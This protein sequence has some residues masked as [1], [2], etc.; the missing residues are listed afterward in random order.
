MEWSFLV[1]VQFRNNIHVKMKHVQHFVCVFQC[2]RNKTLHFFLTEKNFQVA[3]DWYNLA[4]EIVFTQAHR[5]YYKLLYSTTDR[6]ALCVEKAFTIQFP[7]RS[8]CFKWRSE[9]KNIVELLSISLAFFLCVQ[10]HWKHFILQKFILNRVFQNHIIS[11]LL[12][13]ICQSPCARPAVSYK[14]S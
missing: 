13:Q 1:E 10:K 6:S 5:V 7:M 12:Q 11:S 8:I 14:M 3:T 4:V 9:R 2:I